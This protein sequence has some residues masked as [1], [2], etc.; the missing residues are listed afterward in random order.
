M[1]GFGIVGLKFRNRLYKFGEIIN[2]LFL[3]SF[4][5]TYDSRVS[6]KANSR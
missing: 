5:L 6:Q 2:L 3:K 4:F 1:Q